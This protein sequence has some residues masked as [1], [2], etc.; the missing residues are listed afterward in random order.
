[1]QPP[2]CARAVLDVLRS[3][4]FDEWRVLAVAGESGAGK[5]QLADA[6]ADVIGAER[7]H[8]DDFF[9]LPP[10]ANRLARLEDLGRVG[11]SE[12]DLDAMAAA[13]R[14]HPG[15]LVVEG[16]YVFMLDRI[17]VR[18]FID[19]TWQQ[20]AAD[21]ATRGRDAVEPWL[22]EVLAIEAPII[23]GLVDRAHV[24]VNQAFEPRAAE[25]PP[26]ATP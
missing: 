13:I 2:E 25:R 9:F 20:T 21:R 6:I 10:D 16:T 5:T 8:Q 18:V 3:S 17:D 15:R 26:L 22:D 12:V 7:L 19:R 24:I 1:M 11:P 4:G 14:R 23:R